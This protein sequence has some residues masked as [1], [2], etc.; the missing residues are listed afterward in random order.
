[1]NRL[2]QVNE[3]PKIICSLNIRGSTDLCNW[4]DDVCCLARDFGLF[5][6]KDTMN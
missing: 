4:I 3:S 6:G 2:F 1:M 5:S